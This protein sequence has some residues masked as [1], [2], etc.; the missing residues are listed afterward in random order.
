MTSITSE[1]TWLEDNL[2]N[3]TVITKQDLTPA[4]CDRI[5]NAFFL[6]PS[7]FNALKNRPPTEW[8]NVLVNQRCS[9][10][11]NIVDDFQI[12]PHGR[13]Y[14]VPCI[15]ASAAEDI[16]TRE[17]TDRCTGC[18]QGKGGKWVGCQTLEGLF[19][20]ACLNCAYGGHPERC[21]LTSSATGRSPTSPTPPT[22]RPVS[23][24]TI[25]SPPSPAEGTGQLYSW[26]WKQS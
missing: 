25:P 17:G 8:M 15:V 22:P 19:H 6:D 20:G 10:T 11:P 5:L 16:I 2:I 26:Q 12:N 24:P 7:V 21:D 23:P 1:L 4:F 14:Y 3:K 18:A 9:R 13:H